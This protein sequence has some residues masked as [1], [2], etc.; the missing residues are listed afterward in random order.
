MA[1][2]PLTSA[3]YQIKR[4][5]RDSIGWVRV[6][7]LKGSG[8]LIVGFDVAHELAAQVGNG[9]EDSAGNNVALDFGE[10]VFDLIEPGTISGRVMQRH[11]GMVDKEAI[12]ELGFVGGEVVHDEVDFLAGG[13]CGDD[14]FEKADKLLAGVAAGSAS[15][16][17]AAPG[18]EGGIK[19]ESAVTE[20]LEPMTLCP[21]RRERQHGIEP[22]EGLDGGLFIHTEDGSMDWRGQIESND[23]G[24][25][26]FEGWIVGSHEVAQAMRLQ[27][28]APPD[29]SDAH[30]SDAKFACQP[31]AAPVSAAVIG[32]APRPLQHFGLQSGRIGSCLTPAML[33]DKTTQAYL[34]EPIGPALN[35]GSTAPQS[36]GDLAHALPARTPQDDIGT[37]GILG[38]HAAR[39]QAASKFTTFG[40]TQHQTFG[41]HPA[42]IA[43]A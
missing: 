12:H 6:S 8:S 30:V 21:S 19:G 22:V 18:L 5:R 38:T 11:V 28:V 7:P 29:A 40:W 2:F 37:A 15:N 39:T 4:L 26:R 31:T 13:L 34:A 43:S 32:A 25:F 23:V 33:G 36:P 10:P 24:R 16:D 9:F 14:L 35:I 27:P 20:I 3:A 42:I 1:G 17:L 41:C